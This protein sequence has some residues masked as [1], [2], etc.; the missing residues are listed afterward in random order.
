M[1]PDPAH[2][3]RRGAARSR[4]HRGAPRGPAAALMEASSR[5]ALEA[6]VRSETGRVL[7]SLIASFGDF[8]L[9]EDALQD[10]VAAAL[11]RWPEAGVP[12]QPAA[13]LLVAA[14]RRAIDRLRH[15][16]MRADKDEALRAEEA[17]RRSEV[18]DQEADET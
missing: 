12:R 3:R 15:R 9:A 10:A 18:A 7:A 2:R 5:E 14:R 1:L 16:T 8:D 4:P 6:I 13:W 17:R 11:E